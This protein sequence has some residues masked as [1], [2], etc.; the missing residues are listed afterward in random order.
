[1]E[2]LRPQYEPLEGGWVRWSSCATLVP[3]P[4]YEQMVNTIIF[5]TPS[6][7]A[8]RT[9]YRW[10]NWGVHT[11]PKRLYGRIR[12]TISFLTSLLKLVLFIRDLLP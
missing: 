5:G 6:P 2:V 3:N 7:H 10:H 4:E 1:M 11:M 8:T 9:L 12:E